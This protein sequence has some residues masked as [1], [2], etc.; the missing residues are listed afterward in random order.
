M[1]ES[2]SRKKKAYTPPPATPRAKQEGNPRWLVPVMV[3]LLVLGLL[4]VV[5]TYLSGAQFPVP[6]LQNWNLAIGFALIIAG[7][8]LTTRWR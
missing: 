3:G 4:W 2:R 8:I 1:P 5:V 6:G 7:F